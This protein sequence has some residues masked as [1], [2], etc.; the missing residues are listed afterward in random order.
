MRTIKASR[1]ESAYLPLFWPVR[2][3]GAAVQ[4]KLGFY[5]IMKINKIYWFPVNHDLHNIKTFSR[6]QYI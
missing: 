3:S 4:P 5:K 2:Q 6:F 1:N